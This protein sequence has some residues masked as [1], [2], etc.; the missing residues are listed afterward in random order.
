MERPAKNRSSTMRACCGSIEERRS[1]ASW[2]ARM[3]VSGAAASSSAWPSVTAN[4][5]PPR[6]CAC[7]E[8]A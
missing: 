5:E 7:L 3:S 4:F 1:S 6:F 8:R 2:T